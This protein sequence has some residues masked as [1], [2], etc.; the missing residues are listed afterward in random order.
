MIMSG[1]EANWEAREARR[2]QWVYEQN[3]INKEAQGENDRR[4]RE[5]MR[6]FSRNDSYLYNYRGSDDWHMGY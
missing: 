5:A 1:L 3:R 6:D 2:Q 4:F